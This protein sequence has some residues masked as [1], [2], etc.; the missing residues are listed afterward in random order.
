MGLPWP[1]VDAFLAF[2]LRPE[3]ATRQEWPQLVQLLDDLAVARHRCPA[4]DCAEDDA[5]PRSQ[6]EVLRPSLSRRFPQFGYYHCISPLVGGD[7]DFAE[8]PWSVTRSTT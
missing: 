7:L 3:P 1:A 4:P 8:G 6:Y 5:A 2:A